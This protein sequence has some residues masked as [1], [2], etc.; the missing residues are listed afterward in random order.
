M[1]TLIVLFW[2]VCLVNSEKRIVLHSTTD[3]AQKLLQLESEFE[4]F[5]TKIS[6]L[7]TENAALKDQLKTKTGMKYFFISIMHTCSKF[8]P[9]ISSYLFE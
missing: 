7:E 5:K 9:H 6:V 8:S 1:E 2:F 3:V 4:A